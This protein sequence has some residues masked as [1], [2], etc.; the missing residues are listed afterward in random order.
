MQGGR[1]QGE[2]S[3]RLPSPLRTKRTVSQGTQVVV[4][5]TGVWISDTWDP[6]Q[7]PDF[8]NHG[9]YMCAVTCQ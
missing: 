9:I 3:S 7:T 8:Q 2:G 4:D 5:A 1:E 6:C